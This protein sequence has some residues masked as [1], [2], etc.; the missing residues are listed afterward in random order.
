M[1]ILSK[2]NK[3]EGQGGDGDDPNA[4]QRRN[5]RLTNA[6]GMLHVE[7][8]TSRRVGTG[9]DRFFISNNF[10]S[11]CYRTPVPSLRPVRS[12]MKLI[13]TDRCCTAVRSL[14]PVR[15]PMKCLLLISIEPHV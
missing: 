3:R 11:G 10:S 12:P 8:R 14:R 6:A 1:Y 15:S 5:K 9:C 7:Y 13:H 2:K 4:P